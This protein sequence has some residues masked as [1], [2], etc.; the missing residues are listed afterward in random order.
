MKLMRLVSRTSGGVPA[1]TERLVRRMLCP[2]TGLTQGI[3]FIMRDPMEPS[4]AVAGGEMT[5]VH[6]L[7]GF[8]PPRPGSYHIGGAGTTY[9]EALIKTLG[10]TIERYSHFAVLAGGLPVTI[11]SPRDMRVGRAQAM[12]PDSSALYSPEQLARPRFPF[13]QL[14]DD[15]EIGWVG[16]R[17]L[18]GG[19]PIAVPAQQA[20]V[21]YARTTGEPMF[22]LGVT[23]G[24]AAHTDREKALRNALL[25]VVQI[26]AAIGHWYGAKPAVRINF[27]ERV[28][29]AERAIGRTLYRHGPSLRFFWLPSADLPGLSVA[30][31]VESGDVPHVG[32]GLG[33]DLCLS[34]AI[35]KAFLEG[36]AVM[37]L[38]KVVLF[39]QGVEDASGVA[40]TA[41]RPFYDL[42]SN[43]GHYAA[44]AD[45]G[46]LEIRFPNTPSIAAS[47]VDADVCGSTNDEIAT[48]INAFPTTGK[49]LAVLDLTTP[50][51]ADL[52][53]SALRVWSPDTLSLP[54]PSAPPLRHPRF[55]AYGGVVH[56]R[57]HPF[58]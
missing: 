57:P 45:A 14:A 37:H 31:L 6:V 7:R 16:A 28:A 36:V 34:R 53:F 54:L 22:A 56:E 18:P 32:V 27:D 2:L 55:A 15:D 19:G 17:S 8:Q 20:L 13:S 25:E 50:D 49:R 42:D 21:G 30:C 29:V 1:T 51:V 12:L 58:P 41:D 52:G 5:G 40:G 11:A 10:E 24:S 9:S 46:V 44:G 38:A 47:D 3:G 33:C 23:T 43:V 35:Y 4:L 26:D 48:L 39:R